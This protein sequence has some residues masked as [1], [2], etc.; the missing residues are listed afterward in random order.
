M[1]YGTI[2]GPDGKPL[3]TRAGGTVRLRDLL[4]AAVARVRDVVAEK[5]SELTPD[6][7]DTV[8]E[9][10]G[11]GAVK[12]ADLSTSRVKDYT[13]DPVRMTALNGNTGVYLQYAHARVCS[14]LRKA[15]DTTH[16][17][18]DPGVALEPAER[19]LALTL[20]AYGTVLDEVAESLE[21]HRLAGYLYELA[22]VFTTFYDSCQVRT[23]SEPVRSNRIVLCG[24]TAATLE[25]GL[26]QLGIAA[27]QRM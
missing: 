20:D 18:V 23:A 25:R 3:E 7:L 26:G 27:P 19:A 17:T 1:A 15:A 4:D 12:Y 22:R 9:Q 14:I 8:A 24:L 10:A 2:L 21:P 6:E 16:A 13:F 5:N 11:I